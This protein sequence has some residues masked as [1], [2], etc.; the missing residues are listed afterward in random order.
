MSDII[1]S[2]VIPSFDEMA[3]L[4]KGVLEKV[5]VFL[6]KKNIQYEV[7]VVD[8]G[9]R[10]GSTAFVKQFTKENSR[11]KLI[12]NSHTGKAG[13][14]AKG[15]LSAKGK[16]VVFTDMDQATPIE[17]IDTLL[18]FLES[19]KYQVAI[20]SRTTGG[21]GYPFS[22]QILHDVGILLRKTIVG[23]PEVFDTQCGFKMFTNEA[24]QTIFAQLT[25]IHNGFK[26]I[27]K[28]AV[29]FGF[30]VEVLLIAKS[31]GY[32]IKEV[33]VHWLYVESRRVSP[34]R[35][36][37]DGIINLF[38]IRIKKMHGVYR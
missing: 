25:S 13:A 29:Q 2:V 33:P 24:A 37:V 34:L 31:K 17:E 14:V 15:M 18:P 26:E 19:G 30:D 32:G 28:S 38:R 4:R 3:N 36:S 27:T 35:D 1:L 12:E 21:L 11:F 8:D 20:G 22:R 10:D 7:I 16:Y 5:K 23:L 9:S 6:D